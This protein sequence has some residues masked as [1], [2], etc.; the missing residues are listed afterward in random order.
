MVYL[1]HV[2]DTLPIVSNTFVGIYNTNEISKR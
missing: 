2:N 1:F